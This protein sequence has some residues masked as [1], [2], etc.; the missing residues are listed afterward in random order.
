[1]VYEIDLV[2]KSL[3]AFQSIERFNP[4]NSWMPVTQS[5]DASS[6]GENRADFFN[7]HQSSYSAS[8]SGPILSSSSES[9]S[10]KSSR[11]SS[12]CPLHLSVLPVF[13]VHELPDNKLHDA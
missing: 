4:D 12:V 13:L 8:Y 1:V 2:S 3:D 5:G 7:A 10:S 11:H 9:K 6:N